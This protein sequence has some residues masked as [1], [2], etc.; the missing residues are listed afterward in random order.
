MELVEVVR[1]LLFGKNSDFRFTKISPLEP[2]RTL[3]L[4]TGCTAH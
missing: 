1:P 2:L 4:S 3:Q